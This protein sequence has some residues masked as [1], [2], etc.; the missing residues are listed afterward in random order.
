MEPSR[1]NT[2]IKDIHNAVRQWPQETEFKLTDEA[3]QRWDDWYILNKQR[4]RE[5]GEAADVVSRTA[6]YALKLGLI[7]AALENS[8][9]VIE[10]GQIEA[11]ILAAEFAQGCAL[12]L[13]EEIGDSKTIK[14]EARI[15]RKLTREPG[16]DKRALQQSVSGR[17]VGSAMFKQTLD[18]M[19]ETGKVALRPSGGLFVG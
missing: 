19:M 10:D 6:P 3:A 2:V 4:E 5:L 17:N 7:F 16:T 12:L 1:F 18:A 8:N 13:L 15:I 14:L 11:G 9:P